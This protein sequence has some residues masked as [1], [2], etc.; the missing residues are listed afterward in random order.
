MRKVLIVLSALAV[1]AAPVYAVL[2]DGYCYLENQ[3]NHEGTKVLFTADSPGAVTDSAYTDSTGYYQLDVEIGFYDI[4]FTY[5]YMYYDDEILDQPC[6]G[7]QILPDVTLIQMA[8]HPLSGSLSGVLEGDTVYLAT[9]NLTVDAGDSLTIEPGVTILFDGY[10]HFDINGYLSAEGTEED[11]IK[12][13]P[14]DGVSGWEGID[15]NDS[16]D[17][18][19]KL[20]YCYITGSNSSGISCWSSSPTIENCTINGNSAGYGYGGGLYCNNNSNPSISNCIISENS[21]SNYGGGI[22]SSYSSPFI[23]NCTISGNSVSFHGGGISCWSSSPTIENCTISGNSASSYGGGIHC[24]SSNPAIENC[25]ISGNTAYN[26][27]GIYLSS[28]SPTIENCTISGNT[29]YN[30]GGLYISGGS[31]TIENCTVNGNSVYY[32]GGG[33]YGSATIK[34]CTVKG[35]SA[36]HGGGFYGSATI[37]NCT[38]S[39]NSANYGGGI[40]GSSNILN[41]IVEGN[42]GNYGVYNSQN[43]TIIFSD[44]HNN[45][46]GNFYNQPQ[47][48]GTIVTT[49]ANG[50]SCD[51]FYNIFEDPLFYST[52]GDSAY[53]LTAESPCIDAGDPASPFDPDGT[54]ADIGAFY[55]HQYSIILNPW[56]LDFNLVEVGYFSAKSLWIF[57]KSASP[58]DIFSL[59]NNI[60]VFY[61]NFTSA[62]SLPAG[63]SLEV[64][65]TF[66]PDTIKSYEDTLWVHTSIDTPKAFLYGE[67]IAPIIVS[68]KDSLFFPPT[69]LGFD[70]NLSFVFRNE[71]NDTLI[72]GGIASSDS[73]FTVN[74]PG[75]GAGILP[76]G[77]SDTC[78][79]TFAPVVDTLYI[80]TLFVICDALNAVNDTFAI[81][82]QGECK[83]IPDTVRNL[84]IQMQY[85]DAVLTWDPVT[86][87]IN[88]SPIAVDCYLIFFEENLGEIFN[89]LAYTTYTTYIHEG[90]QQFAP[91]M[92]YNVEAYIGDI[93]LLDVLISSRELV[94]REELTSILE[95]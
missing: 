31:P 4:Y 55:Y 69:E 26:G 81:L 35:N 80:D 48:V 13:M 59:G 16:A 22:Y 44:F 7:P 87:T 19:S 6:F 90:V 79:V 23:S 71:G 12:F 8:G 11:S 40:Y 9:G 68:D 86:T 58:A 83:S 82:M 64:I 72:I 93:G 41:T 29:G 70:T 77:I 1:L 52:T 88:G 89:F 50:D 18:F 42:F 51:M 62:Y 45:E 75:I 39:G 54:V 33:F 91:S 67:G 27:N 17:D 46:N 57:N 25:T 2:V 30:G 34:N 94:S 76:G 56:L 3:T 78:V 21:A 65:V 43:A 49:N 63:D 74:F 5:Y 20:G 61:T 36:N 95:R 85:P 32:Y 60:P 24:E 10:F 66:E 73:V 28:S 47:W 37:K 14:N 92:F 53:Y 38:I 84:A 15:F